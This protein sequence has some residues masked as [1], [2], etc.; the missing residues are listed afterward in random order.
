MKDKEVKQSPREDKRSWMEEKAA[1][2]EKAAEN[3]KNKKLNNITKVIAGEWKS[4]EVGVKDK[5]EILKTEARERLQR[6]VEHFGEILNREDPM[7]PVEEDEREELEEI[8]EIDLGRWRIQEVKNALK[9]TKSGKAAWGIDEVAP[10]L[11]KAGIQNTATMLTKLYNRLWETER[12]PEV[13]KKRLIVKILK[14]GD[15]LRL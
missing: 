9:N 13:W 5:Q 7:D 2:A 1:A 11:L 3:G 15:L 12:W 6:W 4:Q 14:K 10:E 8:A